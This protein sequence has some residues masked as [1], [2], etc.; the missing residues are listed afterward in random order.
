M[1]DDQLLIVAMMKC[2]FLFIYIFLH[3]DMT[4]AWH[5]YSTSVFSHEVEWMNSFFRVLIQVKR[6]PGIDCGENALGT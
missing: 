6:Q 3:I 5:Y 2:L 1:D 4:P